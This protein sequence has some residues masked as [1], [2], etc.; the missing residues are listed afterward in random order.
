MDSMTVNVE[1]LPGAAAE[2]VRIGV[3]A[4]LQ[5]LIKNRIGVTSIVHVVEPE[6]IERS[7]GKARRIIDSRVKD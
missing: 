6:S 4:E 7:L 1:A 5:K 3:A 2:D